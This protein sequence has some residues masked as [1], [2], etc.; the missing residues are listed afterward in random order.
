MALEGLGRWG[1]GGGAWS[2]EM[3]SCSGPR[4][5]SDF[6]FGGWDGSK[7][8]E[9]ERKVSQEPRAQTALLLGEAARSCWSVSLSLRV[10]C[11]TYGT[12]GNE[13]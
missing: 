2:R 10:C 1:G 11:Q 3:L 6:S 13:V 7:G 5:L 4:R 8:P 12:G 9:G